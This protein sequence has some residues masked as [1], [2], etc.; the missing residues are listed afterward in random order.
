[1]SRFRYLFMYS[2]GIFL[3]FASFVVVTVVVGVLINYFVFSITPIKGQSMEPNFHSG[4]W[5]ILDKMAYLHKTPKRGDVVGLRFPGDPNKEKYIKR[6]L[7]LPGDKIVIANGQIFINSKIIK[8]DYLPSETMTS[9][10][11]SI[12][13]KDDQYYLIGDNRNNSSDSRIWGPANLNEFIGKTKFVVFPMKD[14]KFIGT[15]SY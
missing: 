8:E 5:M 11:L 1:M 7:G 14:Y 12:S 15:P 3:E 2:G 10:D 13:L 9:P 4:N 6:V